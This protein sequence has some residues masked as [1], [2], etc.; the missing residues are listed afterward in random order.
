MA[1]PTMATSSLGSLEPEPAEPRTLSIDVGG[2]R[3][4]AGILDT[5]G[6]MVNG[7]VRVNTPNPRGPKDVVALL[8]ELVAGLG[9]FDRIS[10]GFPGVVRAG[11]TLTAPNFGTELW[12]GYPLGAD[13]AKRLGKPAR[14]LNDASV[15]GLGVIAGVGLECVITLGT[16]FGF[17]L[18]QD[19]KLAPHLEVG[20]HPVAKKK[21]YDKYLGN[22]ALHK[23]GRAKWNKR[24]RK[25][26]GFLDTLV[27][28]DTLLIGGG[29]AQVIDFTLP[30]N[31]QLVPNTAGITGGVKL[32]GPRMEEE[33]AEREP[34]HR[35]PPAGVTPAPELPAPS[36]GKSG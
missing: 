30:P 15:Q 1:R 24:L 32:W 3:L 19:G 5:S 10:V 35:P 2:T 12:H 16:G 36:R 33:F 6:A 8:V 17:A 18:F 14:V 25:A 34:L 20:Q 31:V 4:K 11:R 13:L 23:V 29:N 9:P 21:T 27:T 22:A 28:Y 26:L 7:P